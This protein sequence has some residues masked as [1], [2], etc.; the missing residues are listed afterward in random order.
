MYINNTI[1]IVIKL[2]IYIYEEVS[3]RYIY[4][5]LITAHY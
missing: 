4:L 1:D 5:I 2:Y 3:L